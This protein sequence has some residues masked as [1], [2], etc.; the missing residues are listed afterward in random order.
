MWAGTLLKL[1]ENGATN[2]FCRFKRI[3]T[4]SKRLAR[5]QN[6]KLLRVSRITQRDQLVKAK[7]IVLLHSN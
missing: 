3:F 7:K 6:S 4:V 1:T 2:M 5:Q